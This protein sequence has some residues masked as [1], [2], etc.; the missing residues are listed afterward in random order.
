MVLLYGYFRKDV[1]SDS[2]EQLL[3]RRP[4][5]KA[6]SLGLFQADVCSEGCLAIGDLS[7]K[8]EG[9]RYFPEPSIMI[10]SSLHSFNLITD[11]TR[12]KKA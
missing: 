11:F 12:S 5:E 2:D 10:Y 3:S 1:Y 7:R 6:R 9:L 4:G 8:Q